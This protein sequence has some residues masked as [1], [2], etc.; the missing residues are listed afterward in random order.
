VH[1]LF[2]ECRFRKEIRD[3]IHDDVGII[4]NPSFKYKQGNLRWR[5]LQV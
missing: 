5:R 4:S 1:Y 3:Y 2:S